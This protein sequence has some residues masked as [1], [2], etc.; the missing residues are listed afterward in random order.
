MKHDNIRWPARAAGPASGGVSPGRDALSLR[1][2]IEALL[3]DP[4]GSFRPR[5]ITLRPA[6]TAGSDDLLVMQV[7]EH[8]DGAIS[9]V[10]S[11]PLDPGQG[12]VVGGDGSAH[13]A[14]THAPGHARD[15]AHEHEYVLLVCR[16]GNRPEDGGRACWISVLRPRGEEGAAK[17]RVP[18]SPEGGA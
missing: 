14:A 7:A 6:A 1:I 3:L 5:P 9:V 15:H 4:R 12:F 16:P 13:N 11:E 8:A 17:A 2:Q 18:A 10:T